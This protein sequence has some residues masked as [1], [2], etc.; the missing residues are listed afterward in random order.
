MGVA[1]MPSK[2]EMKTIKYRALTREA[3][4]KLTTERIKTLVA[5]LEQK[6]GQIDK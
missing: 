3:P 1:Q 2:N 5:E 6:L 4:D